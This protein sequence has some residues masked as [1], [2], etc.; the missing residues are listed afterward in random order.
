MSSVAKCFYWVNPPLDWIIKSF[1]DH[2]LAHRGSGPVF[3]EARTGHGNINLV[4]QGRKGRVVGI[5]G[6]HISLIAIHQLGADAAGLTGRA[7]R[8]YM[9]EIAEEIYV[10]GQTFGHHLVF[11]SLG[12]QFEEVEDLLA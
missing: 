11:R 6:S 12:L 5:D 3:V 4:A 2:Y 1:R 9:A 10:A 8:L 7:C